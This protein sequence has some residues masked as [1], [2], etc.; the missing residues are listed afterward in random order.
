[1]IHPDFFV[2]PIRI[3][4]AAIIEA[5][6]EI[7]GERDIAFA[8]VNIE[9]FYLSLAGAEIPDRARQVLEETLTRV[10]QRIIDRALNDGLP[11]LPLPVSLFV[12]DL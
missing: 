2:D 6:V 10:I 9:E 11:T 8:N 7:Q 1:M 4:I 3:R 5:G 12:S